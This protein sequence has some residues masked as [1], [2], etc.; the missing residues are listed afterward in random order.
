MNDTFSNLLVHPKTR[1]ELDS[2]LANPHHGLMIVGEAGSGK[3]TLAMATAAYLLNIDTNALDSYPYFIS[4]Y[5]SA[6]EKEIPVEAVRKLLRN[7]QL[8][9]VG[10]ADIR[11]VVLIDE[12]H[13]MSSEAQNALLK[14]LEEPSSDT[15]FILTSPSEKSVLST[16][17]S[18]TQ[19]V[20]VNPT[21]LEQAKSFFSSI[22]PSE[23]VDRAWRLSRGSIGLLAALLS[24]NEQ[25]P[26]KESVNLA[27][28][29][30]RQDPYERLLTLDTI[31]KDKT[32]LGL[33]LD[34]LNRVITSLHHNSI[35]KGNKPHQ[36]RLLASRD[37]LYESQ[38]A[39]EA[40]TNTR[41]VIMQLALNL[42][43]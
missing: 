27:K 42:S 17:V 7:L 24:E 12:A 31:S 35:E 19:V 41:L 30:I 5:K 43:V 22:S 2:F 33:F 6:N 18:R 28:S 38:A 4:L 34:A 26:L 20:T 3:R 36:Q 16:I 15:V 13:A 11:R 10:T 21:S 9:T 32:Q 23:S 14:I 1:Q 37:L 8:K 29:F 25:H 39:L 40:N